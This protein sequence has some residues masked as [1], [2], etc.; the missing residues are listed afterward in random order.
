MFYFL[1]WHCSADDMYIAHGS[2][3][4]TSRG[5]ENMDFTSGTI[6]T[7]SCNSGYELNGGDS[8]ALCHSYNWYKNDDTNTHWTK[9]YCSDINECETNPCPEFSTCVDHVA[10]QTGYTCDCL[11]GYK[12][13]DGKILLKKMFQ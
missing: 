10:P 9:P 1:V 3:V 5:V 2:Y 11:P 7:H 4:V 12:K 6:V 8:Q 13:T